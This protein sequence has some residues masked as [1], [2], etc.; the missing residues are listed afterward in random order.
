MSWTSCDQPWLPITW[1]DRDITRCNPW[2]NH[3]LGESVSQQN[4]AWARARSTRNDRWA[5]FQIPKKHLH[6]HKKRAKSAYYLKNLSGCRNNS[7]KFRKVVKSLNGI[8]LSCLSQYIE[9]GS[10]TVNDKMEI[11][12]VFNDH[13]IKLSSLFDQLNGE[14]ESP[15]VDLNMATLGPNVVHFS[16][17]PT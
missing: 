3:D 12:N 9:T 14:M 13:F 10:I 15:Q 4:K 17:R 11:C 1:S 2:F 6:L 7:A 5:N 16:F 8:T